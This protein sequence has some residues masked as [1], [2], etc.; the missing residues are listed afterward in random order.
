M[1]NIFDKNVF[2]TDLKM[3]EWQKIFETNDT[4]ELIFVDR[5]IWDEKYK[6]DFIVRNY[7]H[8]S[9]KFK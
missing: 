4:V 3:I 8:K 2:D 7:D 9:K 6:N 5:K 1:K